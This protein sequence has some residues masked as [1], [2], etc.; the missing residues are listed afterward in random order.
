MAIRTYLGQTLINATWEGNT[1]INSSYFGPV[2]TDPATVC[3]T[4]SISPDAATSATL[5]AWYDYSSYS[6]SSEATWYDKSG[7]NRHLGRSGSAGGDSA[8][9]Q[10]VAFTGTSFYTGSSTDIVDNIALIQPPFTIMMFYKPAAGI[11]TNTV[12]LLNATSGSTTIQPR[13]MPFNLTKVGSALG[14][15]GALE[16]DPP[17]EE[18]TGSYGFYLTSS[19]W[20]QITVDNKAFTG[21]Q[22]QYNK[23]NIVNTRTL[24]ANFS[25]GTRNY[26]NG[27]FVGGDGVNA[28]SDLPSGSIGAVMIFTGSISIQDICGINN[29]YSSSYGYSQ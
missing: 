8:V 1:R 24:P 14:N 19:Q 17:T 9:D 13:I 23:E 28:T 3:T 15:A 7:N 26:R 29:Y 11:Q 6:G 16:V 18:A 21:T 5:L 10:A 2:P 20:E 25:T 12:A 22:L 27:L 4:A